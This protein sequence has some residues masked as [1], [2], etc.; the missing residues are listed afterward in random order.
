MNKQVATTKIGGGAEYATVPARLKAFR[1][2]NPR[3]LIET[4][5]TVSD[6]MIMFKTRI[7]ADKA[8]TNSPEATGHS[9]GENKGAKA[10]EKLETISVGRALALLGYLNNGQ[11]ASTE[12]MEEFNEY[13]DNKIEDAINSMQEAKTLDQLKDYFISLGNLVTDSRVI[14]AK[15]K[16]KVELSAS[17]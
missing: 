11:I 2:D 12:E 16:R 4:V 9:M 1:E 7:L 15:D 8:D 14:E 17:N 10:F 13:Q 6:G 5:P 3:A